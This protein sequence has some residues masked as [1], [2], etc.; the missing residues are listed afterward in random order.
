MTLTRHPRRRGQRPAVLAAAAAC[1]AASVVGCGGTEKPPPPPPPPKRQAESLPP[2]PPLTIRLEP[3]PQLVIKPGESR[4]VPVTIDRENVLGQV[5]GAAGDAGILGD[6]AFTLGQPPADITVA[7]RP[8]PGEG[9]KTL[10]DVTAAERLGDAEL[11]TSVPITATLRGVS[12]QGDLPIKVVAFTPP[13]VAV[14]AA[15]TAQPGQTVTIRLLV[16]RH[17]FGQPISFEAEKTPAGITCD[18]AADPEHRDITTAT[19]TAAATMPDGRYA[20]NLKGALLGREVRPEVAVRVLARPF[21]FG[22][23]RRVAVAPGATAT[24]DL[25]I[26]RPAY[27]GPIALAI[28]NLPDGV[29]AQSDPL[30]AGATTLHVDVTADAAAPAGLRAARL[31]GTGGRFEVAQ[32]LVIRVT[33]PD[34]TALPDAVSRGSGASR[35]AKPGSY[36]GRLT[37]EGKQS[38]GRLFGGTEQ[39]SAAI[40]RGLA[41]LARNQQAD[42]GW[43]LTDSSGSG[44][45]ATALALLPFLGEGV[46]HERAPDQPRVLMSYTKAVERGLAFLGAGQATDR[47]PQGGR[48][49]TALREHALATIAFCE[50]YALSRDDR[51]KVHARQAV[52]YLVAAQD[53][54]AGGWGPA[55]EKPSDLDTTCWAVAALRS[56]QLSGVGAPKKP[57]ERAERFIEACAAGPNDTA[58]LYG[59]LPGSPPTV[60]ATAAGLLARMSLGWPR[61]RPELQAG[62]GWLVE[63]FPLADNAPFP[64]FDEAWAV[65]QALFHM[66]GEAFDTWYPVVRERLLRDQRTSG[67]EDGSWDPPA[68]TSG[69]TVSRLEATAAALL[70][71]ETPARNLPL[72][73]TMR[74]EG[75]ESGGDDPPD[76]E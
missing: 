41:W 72:Y 64:P 3:I 51:A 32:P 38:L 21:D 68:A 17:G 18:I 6:V 75:R 57:L 5:A 63:H 42:G 48:S 11:V 2:A 35:L 36:G 23:I 28:E 58:S 25:P 40:R 74:R 76:P 45:A 26:Q 65:S 70:T 12:A 9:W 54:N 1:L 59:P 7:A 69:R 29:R 66:E 52:T 15:P 60:A 61:D 24:V 10:V 39:S 33:E 50:D 34:P 20:I 16:E 71:L 62:A 13:T 67:A 31:R 14:D 4:T 53:E 30:T 46:S 27:D 22:P 55:P 43:T 8:L 47:G 19:V 73:R 49:G 44:T 37:A 56:A